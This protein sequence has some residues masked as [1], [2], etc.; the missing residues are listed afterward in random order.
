MTKYPP[1]QV[2]GVISLL[3]VALYIERYLS[4]SENPITTPLMILFWLG[5]AYLI[6]PQ[7]FRKYQLWIFIVYGLVICYHFVVFFQ[8]PDYDGSDRVNFANMMLIPLPV[9]AALWG[10]EQ[11]RWLR[12]LQADK[13]EA[14][15]ALLKSQVNPH[16]FF[17]TLNNLY[18][19]VVEKSE[20]APAVVLK[21]S[22][23]MR[24]TIY[25]GKEAQVLLSGEIQYLETYIE[26]HNI[27]YQKQVDISFTHSADPGIK[28]APLLFIIL[29]EN[30][31]K[32]GVESLREEAYIHLHLEAKGKQ[33]TFSIENNYDPSTSPRPRGIGLENLE[34]RLKHIYPK[35][36]ELKIDQ[37]AGVYRVKLG[38]EL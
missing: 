18:G 34:K 1:Y 24:Y 26:L 21:L 38:F 10:Y 36:H 8:T 20:Q 17:N 32:H 9:F 6:V 29:L 27:R 14:E 12:A 11:W 23:M 37:Q 19:L 30:A 16:F 31:F 15:L 13:A 28:V 7:F 33:L 25:Q 22:D 3:V 35:R 4:I 5:V 2:A